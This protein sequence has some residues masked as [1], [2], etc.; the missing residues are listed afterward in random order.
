MNVIILA[1]GYAERLW[2]LTTELPK[3]LLVVAGKPVLCFLLNNLSKVAGVKSITIAIDENKE[4]YF[5]KRIHAINISSSIR[6]QLSIHRLDRNGNII[7]ALA[8]AREILKDA[9]K[10]RLA[11]DDFLILGGDNV[12]CFDLNR[13]VAYY[14]ENGQNCIAVQKKLEPI[15]AS[16][17]GIP[18][19]DKSGQVKGLIE[20]PDSGRVTLI[21]TACYCLKGDA[22][23]NVSNYLEGHNPDNL[24]A[25]LNWLS[26]K[27]R[28]TS[29][30]FDDEWYDIGRREYL[31]DCNAALMKLGFSSTRSPELVRGKTVLRNPVF[32]EASAIL[33]GST[34]GP[35]VYIGS[36]CTIVKSRVQNSVIYDGC[37]LKNCTVTDSVIGHGSVLEGNISEAV[38]GPNTR[39]CWRIESSKNG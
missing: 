2:P 11:D 24:G 33:D 22:V 31:I 12:F 15:D 1:G 7:G 32:C 8:K 9:K 38:L 4:D 5:V 17:Y 20:K 13:V 35:N 34:I 26:K 6:P 23:R 21:S 36:D 14:Q 16:S 28:I 39:A 19:I 18:T 30:Q 37:V 25:F 10:F 29:Y 27:T 3:T